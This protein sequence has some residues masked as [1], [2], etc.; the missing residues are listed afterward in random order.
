HRMELQ[1]FGTRAP[2]EP[3]LSE[4]ACQRDRGR[5]DRVRASEL[6]R[7]DEGGGEVGQELDPAVALAGEEQ[8]GPVEQR[9]RG[10][11]VAADVRPLACC[12]EVL[13]RAEPELL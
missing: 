6:A 7:V 13:G 12:G 5:E 9:D 1:E 4:L 11:R 3:L 2:F 10:R 8:D